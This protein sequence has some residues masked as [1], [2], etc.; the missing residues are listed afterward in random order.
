MSSI[1]SIDQR[2]IQVLP[3]RSRLKL[4]R[5]IQSAR[6]AEASY[7][8]A[9]SQGEQMREDIGHVEDERR[10]II[11]N[12]TALGNDE[13]DTADVD[14][15]IKQLR[16]E[17]A[18][19]DQQR[20]KRAERRYAEAQLIA[21]LRH[22]LEQV[23]PGV[24]LVHSQQVSPRVNAGESALDAVNRIRAEISKL[25]NEL[26]A[27]A[28]APLPAGEL[29]EKARAYVAELAKAGRP[30]LMAERGDFRIDWAP[31][32]Q[33]AMGTLGPGAACIIA[34]INPDGLLGL[35]EDQITKVSG[36]GLASTER[37]AREEAIRDRIHAL[38]VMEES[39]IEH[40]DASNDTFGIVRRV[41]ADPMVVLGARPSTA[42][43]AKAS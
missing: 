14:A 43:Q 25:Q 20:D 36:S 31:G 12:A 15:A 9:I 27:I 41:D 33:T 13:P 40:D 19:I 29:R 10:Q 35:I 24:V 8:S 4:G 26:R 37:P 22:A 2:L 23:P 21:R 3:T 5:L 28:I 34:A 17:L 30:M 1:V 16:G 7:Q 11:A 18:R 39:I 6:D 38:E 42:A 32:V